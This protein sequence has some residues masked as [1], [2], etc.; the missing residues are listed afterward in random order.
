MPPYTIAIIVIV[1]IAVIAA[2]AFFIV[3]RMDTPKPDGA[4][5]VRLIEIEQAGW[6]IVDVVDLNSEC[7]TV[8]PFPTSEDARRVAENQNNFTVVD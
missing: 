2:S 6:F 1:I 8:G 4:K 5:L 7:E 3:C